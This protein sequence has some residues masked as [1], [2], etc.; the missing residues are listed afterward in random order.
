MTVKRREYAFITCLL[1][2]FESKD[3]QE[4]T[5]VL[6]EEGIQLGLVP[7][8]NINRYVRRN[9]SAFAFKRSSIAC[10]DTNSGNK[11]A[12]HIHFSF[13]RNFFARV[14]VAAGTFRCKMVHV[15]ATITIRQLDKM[16]KVPRDE[17]FPCHPWTG[18]L[19]E[20][21]PSPIVLIEGIFLTHFLHLIND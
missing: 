16:S 14:S 7:Q 8:S 19:A 11:I 15:D 20:I 1:Q 17:G 18:V 21:L 3:F 9:V 12:K 5:S 4:E 13:R 6:F 10:A 2:V